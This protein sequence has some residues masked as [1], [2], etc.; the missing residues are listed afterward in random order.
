MTALS[1]MLVVLASIATL[2]TRPVVNVEGSVLYGDFLGAAPLTFFI[3][4]SFVVLLVMG[5]VF[6]FIESDWYR[7]S[8][9]ALTFV[10]GIYQILPQLKGYYLYAG[11]DPSNHIGSIISIL[12]SGR[13]SGLN[14]YPALHVSSASLIYVTGL[15]T[16][17]IL[18]IFAEIFYFAFILGG[19]LVARTLFQ[20]RSSRQLAFLML[21]SYAIGTFFVP[22]NY[23]LALLPLVFFLAYVPNRSATVLL[24]ILS[25]ALAV[26]HPLVAALAA[27]SMLAWASASRR[28]LARY[29]APAIFILTWVAFNIALSHSVA[30]VIQAFSLG[31]SSETQLVVEATSNLGWVNAAEI[32]LRQIGLL[33]LV[34]IVELIW[35]MRKAT[36]RTRLGLVFFFLALSFLILPSTLVIRSA[37]LGYQRFL[38]YEQ[39]AAL[40]ALGALIPNRPL[41]S[42][43]KTLV[44]VALILIFT[45]NVIPAFPSWYTF[46]GNLQITRNMYAS[47]T[48]MMNAIAPDTA[49]GG[50]LFDPTNAWNLVMGTSLVAG[51]V[52]QFYP[53][54]SLDV[55]PHFEVKSSPNTGNLIV[56]TRVATLAYETLYSRVGTFNSSDFIRVLNSHHYDIVYSS[57]DASLAYSYNSQ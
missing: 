8:L 16:W 48:W 29:L 28:P 11:G 32:F 22:Q 37:S 4:T 30:S 49:I 51:S 52:Y 2:L 27:I 57:L 42:S 12:D 24:L 1:V 56:L 39:L 38:P 5:I 35:I 25:G 53:F 31:A 21:P 47:D 33:P 40:F 10:G 6:T 55:G 44:S 50:P 13:V 26:T 46:S 45:A 20:S 3:F 43:H 19:M 41:R 15:P 54:K 36:Y 9:M 17:N 23:A 18:P 14:I 7:P 34:G